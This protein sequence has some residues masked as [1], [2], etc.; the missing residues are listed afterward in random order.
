M[1]P[2]SRCTRIE[3]GKPVAALPRDIGDL[4]EGAPDVRLAGAQVGGDLVQPAEQAFQLAAFGRG[5]AVVHVDDFAA[6]GQRHAEPPAAQDQP[7]PG[8]IA[9]VVDPVRPFAGR[10]DQPF[11][12][13]EAQRA[14]RDAKFVGELTHGP[15]ALFRPARHPAIVA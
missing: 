14:G 15:G 11:G 4:G 10:P 3:F 9:L 8:P 6:F 1:W 12:F 13:V 2:L 7:Q 5:R